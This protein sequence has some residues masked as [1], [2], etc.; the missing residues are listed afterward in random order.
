MRL[1]LE[2]ISFLKYCS[3][4]PYCSFLQFVSKL[5]FN[6]LLPEYIFQRVSS[7]LLL[8]GLLLEFTLFSFRSHFFRPGL[9]FLFGPFPVVRTN[10]SFHVIVKM[11]FI[12]I[13]PLVYIILVRPGATISLIRH[14]C[15]Y[16]TH[17]LQGEP[18]EFT[19][20]MAHYRAPRVKNYILE[21][22]W[23]VK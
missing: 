12:Q 11:K 8:I 13:K 22:F 9:K 21:L 7:E 3:S 1:A 10:S 2:L 14:C 23:T 20:R 18:L 19:A 4:E 15:Q 6:S 16:C 17:N 5:S